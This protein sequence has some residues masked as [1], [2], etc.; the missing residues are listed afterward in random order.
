MTEPYKIKT[1]KNTKSEIESG[2]VRNDMKVSTS[3][4]KGGCESEGCNCNPG[5]WACVSTGK[6]KSGGNQ[7]A[8]MYLHNRKG[9]LDSIKNDGPAK[10]RK[11]IKPGK[12]K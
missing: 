1:W 12:V 6:T 11:Q 3:A 8:T 4:P 10:F 9:L 5:H 7:A 2:L